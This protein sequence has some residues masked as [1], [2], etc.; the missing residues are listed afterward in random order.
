MKKDELIEKWLKNELSA[1]EKKA[2][3]QL[4]DADFN[5]FIVDYAQHFKASNHTQLNDFET[6][7][8]RYENHKKPVRKLHWFNPLLKIASVI[9]VA[10]G[11]YFTL[12]YNQE[13]NIQTL[14]SETTKVT[15]PDNSLVE[16]NQLSELVY[17]KNS[18]SEKRELELDGEAFFDVEKGQ[19]FDVNTNYGT[20][21]VLG[22]EFN[23][24]SRDSIFKVSCY[25]GLVQVS[26]NNTVKKLP[27]G[28]EITFIAGHEK[29]SIVVV[30]K[31]YWLKN[32]S[33]FQN[34]SVADVIAELEK[35]F[36]VTIT[37]KG[38]PD[39]NFT[40]AFEHQDLDNALKSITN[41]LN[42]SYVMEDNN[43]I[44]ITNAS[45]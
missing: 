13:A 10:L 30:S 18:W 44:I 22:T 36:E 45:N 15:L 8:A 37:Y 20:V 2:F 34:A 17:N 5:S 40:G 7:K 16:L 32:R 41:P 23:V 11:L 1:E 29:E 14:A 28:S 31:P 42:L 43:E 26:Y 12:F 4:D 19:R 24:L 25:E 9:V 38:N 27:A 6:F 3:Q 33:E 35:H 39:L 21:S